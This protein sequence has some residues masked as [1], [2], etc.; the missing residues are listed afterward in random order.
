MTRLEKAAE[1]L[2]LLNEAESAMIAHEREKVVRVF[3]PKRR[4][5]EQEFQDALKEEMK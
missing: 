5:V 3:A 4:Q 1:A 2:R